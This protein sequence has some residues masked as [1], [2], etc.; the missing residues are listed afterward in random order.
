MKKK[1]KAGWIILSII[2]VAA[3]AFLV[4]VVMNFISVKTEEYRSIKIAEH[5]GE[6]V[7]SR[8]EQKIQ[9]E[10][11]NSFSG[12]N[13]KSED[14]VTTEEE[15]HMVLLVDSDKHIYA[16]ENTCFSVISA[17]ETENGNIKIK[18]EYGA[19]LCEIDNKLPEGTVFEVETPNATASVRGT[20]FGVYY[21]E[22]TN[23]TKVE[24]SKGAVE[25]QTPSGTERIEV[26]EAV[27]ITGDEG[28]I[29]PEINLEE[30]DSII[31]LMESMLAAQI[32]AEDSVNGDR[33][34]DD[35]TKREYVVVYSAAAMMLGTGDG[36]YIF[37][38][39]SDASK[40][41]MEMISQQLSSNFSAIYGNVNINGS[42]IKITYQQIP[43]WGMDIVKDF[44]ADSDDYMRD[45]TFDAL[46]MGET[47][48]SG[49]LSDIME[50]IMKL[51]FD[52]KVVEATPY[53]FYSGLGL[54]EE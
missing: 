42:R 6:I 12:M 5:N 10:E 50:S 16:D 7:L 49:E 25:V 24:V 31:S 36:F 19:A 2:S 15:A 26:G 23:E 52:F 34:L 29:S 39:G 30:F 33:L 3:I 8:G 17:D 38:S 9:L 22:E 32:P 45:I 43:E 4:V 20:T 44:C 41:E 14:V 47:S 54:I 13:L 35:T 18:L 21:D 40:S 46:G 37:E 28:S 48:D 11:E 1:G 27:L 53:D 51:I